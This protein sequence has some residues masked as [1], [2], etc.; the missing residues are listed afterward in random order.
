MKEFPEWCMVIHE[1]S[2]LDILLEILYPP[3]NP[4]DVLDLVKRA[5]TD[6]FETW[7]PDKP[8]EKIRVQITSSPDSTPHIFTYQNGVLI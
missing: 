3:D 7:S 6:F 8:V 2:K 1:G 4:N 5:T